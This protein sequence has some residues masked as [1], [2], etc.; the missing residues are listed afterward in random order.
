MKIQP[1]PGIIQIHLD[2]PKAGVLDTSSRNAAVEYAEVLAVGEG[3]DSVKKG[4]YVF[5]K[6]W[7]ID[8]ISHEGKKYYF[9]NP[10]TKGVLAIIK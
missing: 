6:S 5:V 7:A 10:D 2:E 9:I 8:I 1:L 4:D 3:V